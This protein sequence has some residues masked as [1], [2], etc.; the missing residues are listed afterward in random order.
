MPVITVPTRSKRWSTRQVEIPDPSRLMDR[1]SNA[2]HRRSESGKSQSGRRWTDKI[3]RAARTMSDT[4]IH[5][6]R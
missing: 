5:T 4:H 3:G 6:R 2:L 1:V